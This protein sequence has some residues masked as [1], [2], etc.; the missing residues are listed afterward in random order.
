MSWGFHRHLPEVD[1]RQTEALTEGRPGPWTATPGPIKRLV[2]P[3]LRPQIG[4]RPQGVGVALSGSHGS[5]SP[6]GRL[7]M[8]LSVETPD[9]PPQGKM[10]AP[11]LDATM[12]P[13]SLYF[14]QGGR[15]ARVE[16]MRLE[17]TSMPCRSRTPIRTPRR[18][19]SG[20][21]DAPCARRPPAVGA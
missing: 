5:T 17:M 20:E 19:K 12:K 2:A 21:R 7:A 16:I 6:R 4:E 9:A 1:R 10:G 14:L 15:I 11:G 13:Y 8:R 18:R 3:E